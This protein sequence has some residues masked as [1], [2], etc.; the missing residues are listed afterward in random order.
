MTEPTYHLRPDVDVQLDMLV[1]RL[2]AARG[3]EHGETPRLILR[4][5]L[6]DCWHRGWMRGYDDAGQDGPT[7]ANPYHYRDNA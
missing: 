5:V 7:A 3:L 6:A 1:Q 4:D 2:E